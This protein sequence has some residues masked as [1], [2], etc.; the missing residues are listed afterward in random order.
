MLLNCGVGEDSRVPWTARRSNQSIVK[1]ISPEY[2]LEGLI[3][4]L[5]L[6][7]F[8][9]TWCEELTHWKRPWCWERLKSGG[10]KGD[11]RW[12]GWMVSLTQWTWVW[13]N[14][15]RWWSTGKPSVGQ[16]LGLQSQTRLSNWTAITIDYRISW[17][18]WTYKDSKNISNWQWLGGSRMDEV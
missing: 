2:S 5:K 6:Q 11:R 18:R 15:Q 10:E 8:G 12:D 9:P 3:L 4:K 7:Y 1:E 16:S 13:A 17:K 14:L